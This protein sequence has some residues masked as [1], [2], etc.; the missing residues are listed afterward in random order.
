M[1]NLAFLVLFAS[2]HAVTAKH[3]SPAPAPTPEVPSY[4]SSPAA[5]PTLG[6]PISAPHTPQSFSPSYISS[7]AAAPTPGM[8]SSDPRT[9]QS[10]SPSYISSPATAP[11]P[12]MP[13]STPHNP[14][15]SSPSYTSSP[16]A[17]PSN[18]SSSEILAS[19]VPSPYSS[20]PNFQDRSSHDATPA[21]AP[22]Y[23]FPSSAPV[24]SPQDS[25]PSYISPLAAPTPS[26]PST[27][28]LS[29]AMPTPSPSTNL[30]LKVGYYKRSCPQAENIIRAA[31][32]SATSKNP[33]IGA[34]LIRLHFHDCFVQGCDAS[35]LLDPTP[36]NL[37]PEKLSPP[38]VQSLRG[39][40]VIDL[41]KKALE[42]VCPG[43]VSCAD[44]IALAARDASLFLSSGKINFQMPAGRLDGRVSLSSE[45]LQFLPPPFS[46]LSQ[47]INIFK[48]KNLDEDDLVVLSGAHSIGV[49]HCSSFTGFLA[50]N[51]PAMD[52]AFAAKI[53]SKC[54][55]RPNV[56]SDPTVMQDIMT[57]NQLDSRY[58]TNILKR[59]VLFASDAALLSS[60]RTTIKVL[61]NAFIP[62]RWE[63]KFAKA[64]VKMAAIELKT[65]ANGE[66]RRMCRV[67]NN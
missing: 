40:E 38:N 20:P 3:G 7:P 32:R 25:L 11:T 27:A 15:S 45:A 10:F 58:Y 34:G 4:I 44:I 42:K 54:A 66:I 55:L 13:S 26:P 56:S 31:V 65:A 36:T 53:Q 6:M 35:V 22:S 8:P 1:A 63:M 2:L 64:M 41:A 5:A 59:N 62:S 14:Q 67:I 28:T 57:P 37:Q 52:P 51:P 47:L 49:S 16:A 39:F 48:A 19:S 50:P 23:S 46:N 43:R 61:E 30:R 24:P 18:P 21:A 17:S 9:L 33:G 12:E 29:P 60:Q